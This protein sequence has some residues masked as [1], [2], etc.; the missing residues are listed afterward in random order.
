MI[1]TLKPNATE[2]DVSC[3]TEYISKQGLKAEIL[4]GERKTVVAVVGDASLLNA[5]AVGSFR[6]VGE[7]R[8]ITEPY[9]LSSRNNHPEDTI[10]KIANTEIGGKSFTFI[11]GPCAVESEEQIFSAAVAAKK[12]GAT[13]LRGG[14]FKPR[15][16]PYS[17]Q[18]TAKEG[19]SLLVQAA[20]QVGLPCVSEITDAAN[21]D[22]Y[23]DVDVIQVGARNMQNFELLKALSHCQKPVLLKRGF[24]NTVSEF[25]LSA[26]Y[27]LN[28]GNQNVVLCTRGIRSFDDTMRFTPD[29]GAVVAL[30]QLTHLPVIFDPSHSSGN[31]SYVLPLSYAAAA[32]GA[33]GIAVEVCDNPHL[34]LSDASQAITSDQFTV[35]HGNIE[36]IKSVLG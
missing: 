5:D 23:D 2:Q 8:R 13:V 6:C 16:S 11:A 10:V 30:I 28:G 18:G 14:A 32:A 19:L 31:S 21:L 7:V 24:G 4:N 1:I 15:T 17:F 33:N 12:A 22:L 35:L 29:I 3:L 26:E 9:R 20:R 34:A 36:K 27:L 25:L